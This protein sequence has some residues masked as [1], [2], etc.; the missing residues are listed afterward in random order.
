MLIDDKEIAATV[1]SVAVVHAFGGGEIMADIGICLDDASSHGI[2]E[3]AAF[4]YSGDPFP[5]LAT[6]DGRTITGRVRLNGLVVNGR[7]T[8]TG[9]LRAEEAPLPLHR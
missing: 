4:E 2:V 8:L 9:I 3:R 5:L 6:W 7:A 1:T